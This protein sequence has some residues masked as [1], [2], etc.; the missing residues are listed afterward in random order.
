[1]WFVGAHSDVGGGYPRDECGLSDIALDW[2]TRKLSAA[3][4][5]FMTPP[6]YSAKLTG[7]AQDFHTPWTKPPFNVDPQPRKPLPGDVFHPSVQQHW[8]MCPPYQQAWPQDFKFTL[9]G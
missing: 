4:V 5:Q 2:L 7:V 9:P 6:I 8:S 1:M 3:G